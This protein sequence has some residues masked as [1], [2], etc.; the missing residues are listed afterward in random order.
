ML[1]LFAASASLS[2]GGMVLALLLNLLL[3]RI[4][5]PADIGLYAE[6][7]AWHILL[8][9]I[10][11]AGADRLAVREI[12]HLK[13]ATANDKLPHF[14]HC[15][16]SRAF[17]WSSSIGGVFAI[18]WLVI[19]YAQA[20]AKGFSLALACATAP[21]GSLLILN[22]SVLHG[23]SRSKL[24]QLPDQIIRPL[25]LVIL[26]I[27]AWKS[28]L[29]T[30][31][32][33]VLGYAIATLLSLSISGLMVRALPGMAPGTGRPT[34][35]TTR[36]LDTWKSAALTLTGAVV[37]H[38]LSVRMDVVL[39]GL[40]S[41]ATQVGL[42]HV[43]SRIAILSTVLLGLFNLLIGPRAAKMLAMGDLP[44][45]QRHTT[46]GIRGISAITAP[47]FIVLLCFPESVLS[48]FGDEY[49]SAGNILRI[50]AVANIVNIATGPAGTLLNAGKRERD[51]LISVVLG[52]LVTLALAVV[53]IPTYGGI[54]AAY[55]TAGGL[56][57]LNV[58]AAFRLFQTIGINATLFARLS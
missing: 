42:Y 2:A 48:L 54:G 27:L 9:T 19:G 55:A 30:G 37:I 8:A 44:V 34:H 28:G 43:A 20:T 49:R 29:L 13:A 18:L 45:L 32:S 41:D 16:R 3:A 58:F 51:L 39:L 31:A 25:I 24:A 35:M 52:F 33:A 4:T 14:L 12:A 47:L 22:I 56:I 5:G 17:W 11:T 10:G 38:A 40:L 26:A 23:L 46:L 15:M 50:L 7:V 21:L 1:R 57:S 53:L 6:A 36:E